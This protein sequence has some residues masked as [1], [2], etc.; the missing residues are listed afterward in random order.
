VTD[1]RV[2][3]LRGINVGK[4]KRVA[5]A[6]LRRV[7]EDLGYVEVRTLLNSGNVL[8]TV[9][10]KTGGDPGARIEKAIVDRL[11]VS[12]RVIVLGAREVSEALRENPLRSLAKDPSRFLL[13][14]LRDTGSAALVKPLLTRPWAPEAIALRKRIAY[15]WCANGIA[16]GRLW[17]EVNRTVGD[18]GTARNLAT[19]TKL[20]ELI[21]VS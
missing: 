5:M 8:F 20:L 2:A 11:G 14:A 16:A 12:S 4:A 1:R 13:M 19:M 21:Q 9:P 18:S 6:D 17:T 15:L 7:V 3:L 10:G